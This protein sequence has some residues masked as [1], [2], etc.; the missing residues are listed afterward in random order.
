MNEPLCILVIDPNPDHHLLIGYSCQVNKF[1]VNPVFATTTEEAFAYLETYAA[2]KNLFPQ[3]V[4]LDLLLPE[5]EKGL[6]L[7]EEIRT[8]H[9]RLPVIILSNHQD[10]AAIQLAY[11]SG[12]NSFIAKPLSLD[13]WEKHFQ[14]L[15]SYWLDV[16]T[17]APAY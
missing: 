12:A 15:L 11:D 17:L 4:L 1:R 7:L 6:Q 9:P 14:I 13:G 2:N 16:V 5:S 10:Q 3:L 8:R